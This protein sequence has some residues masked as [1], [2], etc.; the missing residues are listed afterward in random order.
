MLTFVLSFN[1]QK[2]SIRKIVFLKNIYK[3]VQRVKQIFKMKY[4]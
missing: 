2:N 1:P 3:Q 4:L